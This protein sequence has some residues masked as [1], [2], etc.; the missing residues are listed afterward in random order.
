VNELY[1]KDIN[2]YSCL[3]VGS[4]INGAAMLLNY[5]GSYLNQARC[6]RDSKIRGVSKLISYLEK[7]LESVD[8]SNVHCVSVC[9]PE[10]NRVGLSASFFSSLEK[11]TI[12]SL[13]K[14]QEL[15]GKSVK[16]Y[17]LGRV[18]VFKA[19]SDLK[20]SLGANSSAL[21][22]ALDTYLF[23]QTLNSLSGQ[24]F[25]LATGIKQ[26]DRALSESNSDGFI[27]GEAVGAMVVA[28]DD[29]LGKKLT[30]QGVGFDSED[31]PLGS[32][33][34]NRGTGLTNAL[35]VASQSASIGLEECGYRV[36]SASGEQY[37]FDELSVVQTR[38][39]KK[40]IKDQPLLLPASNI[41]EVGSVSG[42]AMFLLALYSR[43]NNYVSGNNAALFSSNDDPLRSVC[44]VSLKSGG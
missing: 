27:P 25:D 34:V 30:I 19:V 13:S 29:F 39:L 33:K 26:K 20:D 31:A 37:F 36:A 8:L 15:Q 40:K 28:N 35:K 14:W 42:I 4:D 41:G 12:E 6:D 1:I 32:N 10:K 44:F 16:F 38:G 2:L 9:C 22:I 17:F 18:A 7:V 21:I 3:G 5:N 23:P 11:K 24:G 43:L